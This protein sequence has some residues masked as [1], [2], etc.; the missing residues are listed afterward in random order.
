MPFERPPN[1]AAFGK[2]FV[3]VLL[4]VTGGNL[5]SNWITARAVEYRLEAAATEANARMK[6]EAARLQ[7]AAAAA[8][9]QD[10]KQAAE[11]AAQAQKSRR[12]DRVGVKLSQA[13]AE[14]T[15][16]N[17]ELQSYTTKTEKQRACSKLSEYVQS[18]VE[19]RQ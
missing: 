10:L 12:E 16:A 4:A 7:Q 18:G 13:C 6:Q 11:V 1:D 9:A 8:Q 17:D 19:P 3:V 5:L 2:L 15:R 14:W